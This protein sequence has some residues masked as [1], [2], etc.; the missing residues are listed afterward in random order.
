MKKF[1]FSFPAFP[2]L[3]ISAN[4]LTLVSCDETLESK[5]IE[6]EAIPY[7]PITLTRAE[8]EINEG[9]C[10]FSCR[11]FQAGLEAES[12]KNVCLSP[13]S[14]EISLSMLQCG[15]EE[16]KS[17]ELAE[18]MGLSS[19]S[20]DEIAAFYSKLGKCINEIDNLTTFEK[21]NSF[22]YRG[23]YTL[24]EIFQNRLTTLYEAELNAVDFGDAGTVNK[25]NDW[26][27]K[28]TDNKIKEL[29]DATTPND[30]MHLMDAVY[31]KS[32]WGNAF[33]TTKTT[34]KTFH[35][36]TENDKKVEMMYQENVNVW[37]QNKYTKVSL[38]FGNGAFFMS[39]ILP[40]E[41]VSI[42]EAVRCYCNDYKD[43]IRR[44][45]CCVTSSYYKVWIPKFTTEY[46]CLLK[47]VMDKMGVGEIL[48]PNEGYQIFE[49][50][51]VDAV[52]QILQK[53]Y[54]AID[55][56][57][58]EAASVT[59]IMMSFGDAGPVHSEPTEV[60]I[61]FDRPFAYTIFERSTGCPLFMGCVRNL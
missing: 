28:K 51:M 10:D 60:V 4:C 8:S 1:N 61:T 32:I 45:N 49:N 53:T 2:F 7:V 31:F 59:D 38:P 54:L 34:K 43:L 13:I 47:D 52:T 55:E 35:N 23:D 30:I 20:L 11:F 12:E 40:D 44:K 21:A 19:Y 18:L 9:L 57:N 48:N 50:S 15:M 33:D 16:K 6:A 56:E 41:N 3:F 37:K 27:A 17:Q 39:F 58:A 14:L 46:S 5:T 25:I 22:W 42:S 26:C 36:A 24:T 29:L